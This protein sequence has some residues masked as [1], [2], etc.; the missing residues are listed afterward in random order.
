LTTNDFGSIP[1]N[2]ADMQ[3]MTIPVSDEILTAANM[4]KEEMATAMILEYSMKMF[5]QGTLTLVQSAELCGL[6]IYDFM[7]ALSQA[8]IPVIDYDPKE[9]E[10][11]LSYFQ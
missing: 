2:E 3:K 1:K 6:N 5:R 8:G 7:S 11:E 10:K 9:L 4:N